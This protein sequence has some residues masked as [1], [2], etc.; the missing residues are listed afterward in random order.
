MKKRNA[1]TLIELLAVIVILA[2][3]A[4][5]AVPRIIE[6]LNKARI[7]AAEDSTMGI[8]EAAES[9]VASFMLQ[10][11]GVIPSGDI[12][13][14]CSS[15]GCKL[16]TYLDEYNIENLEE[17]KFKGTKPTKGIITISNNG[18]NIFATN[19]E[20]NGF[21]CNYINSQVGCT[22][23]DEIKYFQTPEV[24]YF[25]P[26]TGKKCD[27]SEYNS[28]NSDTGHKT[29]CMKWY[30]YS[31]NE[32]LGTVDMLLDHNTTAT[33]AWNSTN[34]IYKMKEV[35]V[36]LANDT[37]TW[38]NKLHSRLITTDELLKIMYKN[39]DIDIDIDN[40]FYF[41]LD[42]SLN[43][44]YES[45]TCSIGENKYAWLCDYTQDCER[46]GCNIEQSGSWGYWTSSIGFYDNQIWVVHSW[47]SMITEPSSKPTTYGI[48]PV[49]TISK[50]L[51]N[52]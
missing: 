36:Q 8:V 34:D 45:H 10:N 24:V 7:S 35:V 4:L 48:R 17:L 15:E 5:I 13:F 49:I 50:S 21:T 25:N 44:C 33:V 41:L 19:L 51:I 40:K 23:E 22:I 46:H 27:A 11:H 37:K 9:Y 43:K 39:I 26:E 29:G 3:I 31:E 16:F 14:N 32:K 28:E 1:F 12:L 2:V 20:I 52:N 18:Q 47:G 42:S 38:F 30:L 6:I